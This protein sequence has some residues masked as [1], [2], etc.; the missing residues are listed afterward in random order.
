[1]GSKNAKITYLCRVSKRKVVKFLG[2][3]EILNLLFYLTVTSRLSPPTLAS[4]SSDYLF[5]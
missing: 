4:R 5:Y 3:E 2:M 1:M